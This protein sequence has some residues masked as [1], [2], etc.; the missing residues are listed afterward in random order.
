[1]P[2]VF[3]VELDHPLKHAIGMATLQ[4]SMGPGYIIRASKDQART[5]AD[6]KGGVTSYY[7]N[8]R[9]T[10]TF[11]NLAHVNGD[12][13]QMANKLW[14]FYQS[15]RGG[16]TAFY[17]YNPAERDTP[18]LTGIDQTGRYLVVFE[19]QILERTQF[20]LKLFQAGINLIEVVA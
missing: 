1:M 15:V 2:S 10:L 4:V 18:D 5:R 19:D 7:G 12:S 17:F 14:D 16:F 13:T 20:A 6:G 9:F 8:N 11:D 3:N